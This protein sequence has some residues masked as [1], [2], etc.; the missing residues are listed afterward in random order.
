MGK[1]EAFRIARTDLFF[2]GM[3][4]RQRAGVNIFPSVRQNHYLCFCNTSEC[5][6]EGIAFGIGQVHPSAMPDEV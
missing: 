5:R 1:S 4:W 2:T 6:P 3:R